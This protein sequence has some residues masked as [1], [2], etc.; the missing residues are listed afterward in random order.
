MALVL[1]AAMPVS[2]DDGTETPFLDRLA[3]LEEVAQRLLTGIR[4][5]QDEPDSQAHGLQQVQ[6]IP[7]EVPQRLVVLVHGLDA[8]PSV[9]NDLVPLL[10]E[11]GL[12]VALFRYPSDGPIEES[13]ARL[14]EELKAL[15]AAGT[16]HVD[17]V[18]HSAGGLVTRELLTSPEYY[19]GDGAGTVERPA[20]DRFIMLGTPN[21]GAQLARLQLVGEGKWRQAVTGRVGAEPGDSAIQMIPGSEFLDS[22]NERPRAQHTKYTN[23]AGRISPI[24]ERDVARLVMQCVALAQS[25]VSATWLEDLVSDLDASQSTHLVRLAVRGLGD[26]V[27]S[28]DATRL[29]GVTDVVVVE[30]NHTSM[31][32]RS[33]ADETELPPA[34][35]IILER[36]APETPPVGDTQ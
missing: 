27:V 11:Q 16:T 24:V 20:I 26:G 29:P 6:E 1:S 10:Q 7:G 2:A 14:D 9:W 34:I 3:E 4:A 18:A 32:T 15:A 28:L 25:E 22:I 8:A 12:A 31:I 17:I 30:A 35:P 23:I 19:A 21:Q 13:A 33:G 5:W 36:L